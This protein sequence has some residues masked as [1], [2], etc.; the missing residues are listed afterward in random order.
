[1]ETCLQTQQRFV[2]DNTNLTKAERSGYI[3]LSKTAGFKV[4]GYYFQSKVDEAIERNNNRA[5][6]AHVPEK[7]IRGSYKKLEI[8]DYSEGFDELFYVEIGSDGFIIKDW[9]DEV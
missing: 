2:I 5:G 8:P 9:Q 4:K 3:K 7:G 6:K 1:M